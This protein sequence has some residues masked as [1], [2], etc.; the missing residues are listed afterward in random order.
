VV[1]VSGPR[2]L[3]PPLKKMP[4]VVPV[5]DVGSVMFWMKMFRICAALSTSDGARNEVP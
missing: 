1:A 5:E 3:L 4:R 2:A